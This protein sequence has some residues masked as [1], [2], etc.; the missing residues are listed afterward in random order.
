MDF[1]SRLVISHTSAT[2]GSS[3]FTVESACRGVVQLLLDEGLVDE[4]KQIVDVSSFNLTYCKHAHDCDL[5]L[6]RSLA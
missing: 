4:A 1:L 2:V 5:D 6:V 3:L